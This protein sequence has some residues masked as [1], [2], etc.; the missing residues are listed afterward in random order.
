[1]HLVKKLRV[2]TEYIVSLTESTEIMGII[3]NY[4][5]YE[6]FCIEN[7]FLEKKST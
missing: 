4:I 5:F 6:R 7:D 2:F 3:F 1:M